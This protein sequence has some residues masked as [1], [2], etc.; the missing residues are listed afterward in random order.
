VRHAIFDDF[1]AVGIL[2]PGLRKGEF[3]NCADGRDVL[4]AHRFDDERGGD[5]HR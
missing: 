2:W 5:L 1:A 4:D 3:F